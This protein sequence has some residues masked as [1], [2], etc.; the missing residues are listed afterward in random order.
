M[1]V[2]GGVWEG[3]LEKLNQGVSVIGP[4]DTTVLL[5]DLTWGWI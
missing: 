4:G 3:Y 1:D 2:F 5:G